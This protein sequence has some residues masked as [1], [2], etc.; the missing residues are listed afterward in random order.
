MK[1]IAG[2]FKVRYVFLSGFV[3]FEI[4]WYVYQTMVG[5]NIAYVAL[6]SIY[7]FVF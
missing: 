3:Q 5:K 1:D 7:V 6:R 4:S 2:D